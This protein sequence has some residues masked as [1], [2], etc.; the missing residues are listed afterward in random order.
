MERLLL[1][2]RLGLAALAL[3]GA[4]TLWAPES[5]AITY[6]EPDCTDLATNTGCQHANTVSLSG[7]RKPTQDEESK[8]DSLI[9]FL[10]CSGSLLTK[11]ADRFVI[12]TAG[13]CASAYLA[14]LEDQSIIEV[15]VS[16]DA[17]I[18]R[19]L[20]QISPTV[21][22]PKQY[23]LGGKP[24]LPAEFGPQGVHASNIQFDYAVIVFEIPAAL[25]FTDGGPEGGQLVNLD[26]IDPIVLPGQDYLVDKISGSKSLLITAVGYGTGEA[27]AKPGEGGNQGGAVNSTEEFGQRWMTELTLAFSFMGPESNLLFGSQNPAR[28]NEG[29]C[30]GDSGGPLF[31]V[32]DGVEIQV[33]IT[34][35]GDAICRATSIMA[36]TDAERAVDFL[37]CI[38]SPKAE[39]EDFLVC[40]CN[41]VNKQGEC[42]ED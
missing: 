12:L 7:F 31:Y 16:F 25:R 9:S 32:D 29:T 36:R 39:F 40:G 8:T 38:R 23:I 6:G 10:R 27:H 33:A 13:H 24:V 42:P 26:D 20:P 5:M 17:L 2:S 11:D 19:D 15:G 34:S 14:A 37:S 21:W 28:G 1:A 18:E 30:G 35:S 3:A 41:T 4:A 22:S